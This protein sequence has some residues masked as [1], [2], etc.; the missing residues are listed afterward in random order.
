[1]EFLDSLLLNF[2][3][4]GSTN[5]SDYSGGR[6]A[7]DLTEYINKEAGSRARIVKAPSAVTVLDPSNFDAIALDP[8]K[9][10]FVEFYAP[11]CGHCK[12]LAPTWEKLA[13]AFKNEPNVVIANVDADKHK[14]VGSKFGVSGFPTLVF[15]SKEDKDGEEKYNGAR[16]LAALVAHV[17]SVAGTHRTESGRLDDTVGRF[18]PLDEL[19]KKFMTSPSER[20]AI[21]TAAETEGERLGENAVWYSKF[22]KVISKKGDDWVSTEATR[23]SGLLDGDNISADKVD[24]FTIRKNV[25]AAFSQ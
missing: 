4:K 14:D 1:L 23:L 3:K 16:E 5:P 7:T 19:A 21:Q 10:V 15:L 18:E 20:V 6:T 24:E 2:S 25:L 22:M 9:D 11:W 17:N 12:S 8:K 13:T